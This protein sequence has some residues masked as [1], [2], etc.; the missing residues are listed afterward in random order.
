MARAGRGDAIN[1]ADLPGRSCV[2]VDRKV[3]ATNIKL[4]LGHAGAPSRKAFHDT[5]GK[6]P[7]YDPSRSPEQDRGAKGSRG[8][9]SDPPGDRRA[10]RCALLSGANRADPG[11]EPAQCAA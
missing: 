6:R 9:G 3:T 2:T 4:P 1:S 11:S 8:R 5:P 10:A 7:D